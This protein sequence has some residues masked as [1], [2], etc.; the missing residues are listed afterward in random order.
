MVW[1]R[2]MIVHLIFVKVMVN[3][4]LHIVTT[5]RSECKSRPEMM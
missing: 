1:P 5:G 2:Y 3:P 4:A